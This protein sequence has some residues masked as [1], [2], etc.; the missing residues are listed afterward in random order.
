MWK[1]FIAFIIILYRFVCQM[2][3]IGYKEIYKFFAINLYI[4]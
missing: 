4:L 2:A 3:L 1:D